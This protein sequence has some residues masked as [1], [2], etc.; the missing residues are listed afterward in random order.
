[1]HACPIIVAY[2]HM[3]R[4]NS[5]HYLAYSSHS[6][7]TQNITMRC[8]TNCT[9]RFKFNL[10]ASHYYILRTLNAEY[11]LSESVNINYI[12]MMSVGTLKPTPLLLLQ[13][14]GWLASSKK[15]VKA[16]CF[17]DLQIPEIHVVR[18]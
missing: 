8:S 11:V 6:M 13:A 3:S 10:L 1:M 5:L 2:E 14:S 16:L 9:E 15:A 18:V 7:H 17:P 4:R 12:I